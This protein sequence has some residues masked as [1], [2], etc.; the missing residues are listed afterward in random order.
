[1]IF[2]GITDLPSILAWHDFGDLDRG[3]Q[4]GSLERDDSRVEKRFF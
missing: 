1:M 2:T 4:T 3:L